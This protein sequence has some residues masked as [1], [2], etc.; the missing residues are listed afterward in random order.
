VAAG[1]CEGGTLLAR[2]L[3]MPE[4]IARALGQLMERW[5]GTGFPGEAAGDEIPRPLRVVRVAHDLLAV[6]RARDRE[7]AVSTLGRRRGRGYDPAIVDA[8]LADP[9]G[10]LAA[11]EGP[12]AWARAMAAEP[13]PVVTIPAAGL[14][15][16]ARAV[17]E[18]TDVKAD[19][20]HG[21]SARVADLA[22]VA[23]DAV[24]CS[25]A[26][27]AQVRAA[28]HLHD[29]GRVAVPYGVWATPGPLGVGAWEQV[30]L[31]PYYTERVLERAGA[32][33]PLAPMA[34]AHHERLDGS[35][36]HRR[37]TAPQLGMGARLL[38]AADGY[39][40]MVHARPHRGA[41]RPEDARTR[42]AGMVQ[43]G[44]L[45]RRAVNGV[46]EAAGVAEITMGHG[47]PAGLS[48][49]EVEVLR[50]IAQG[51]TSRQIA[52]ALVISEKTAGHHVEHIYAKIGVRTRVGAALFAM[53]H[54]LLR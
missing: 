50:L 33:A 27:V 19:F 39:D 9:D 26:E 1:I 18:F 28:G 13:R 44:R 32:L 7:A 41:M 42:L 46:L 30:R 4:R 52:R 49:R 53:E 12:D 45:D 40:A 31:H 47:H 51:R 34:A 11:A 35:G 3:R 10:L 38:A 25:V 2:R 48:A 17:G 6:A 14:T 20:M 15:S 36:Y 5:D 37:A 21:H 16:V 8:A 54:D 22:S 43:A 23:A 29:V 24:G